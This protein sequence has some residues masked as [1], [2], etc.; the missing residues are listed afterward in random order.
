MET[1]NGSV[2]TL[3]NVLAAT[4]VSCNLWPAAARVTVKILET[5]NNDEMSQQSYRM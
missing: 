1:G 5:G 2:W 3:S 4:T